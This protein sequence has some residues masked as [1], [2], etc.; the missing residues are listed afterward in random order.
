MFFLIGADYLTFKKLNFSDTYVFRKLIVLGAEGPKNDFSNEN[1]K[2][3]ALRSRIILF[4]KTTHGKNENQSVSAEA[5]IAELLA[6]SKVG[7]DF[8]GRLIQVT[9]Y[10]VQQIS[11]RCCC[12]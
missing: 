3:I 11:V 2:S 1:S 5:G 12:I 7:S 10:D 4:S 6:R 8:L 9:M